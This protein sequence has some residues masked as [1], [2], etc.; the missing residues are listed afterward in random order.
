MSIELQEVIIDR[1]LQTKYSET[2]L[3]QTLDKP[4]SYIIQS[5]NKVP[6]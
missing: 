5:L 1:Y 2:S 6:M 4:E 3:N